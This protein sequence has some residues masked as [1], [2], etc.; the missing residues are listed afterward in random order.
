MRRPRLWPSQKGERIDVVFCEPHDMPI[1]DRVMLY[2]LIRGLKPLR[3][4]EIGVRW[5]GSARIVCNAMESN[6]FGRAV[7]LDPDL[8][9]FR[10]KPSETFGRF[11]TIQG[12]SPE[13]IG[14]AVEKLEGQPDF[15]FIDAVHTY[16]AVKM[17]L[18]GV[19]PYLAEHAHILLHDAF[20][21]GINQAAREF[22]EAH[23]DFFD[24][25]LMSRNASVGHPVSYT[26]MRLLRKGAVD[27]EAAL[28]EAHEREG[29][30]PPEFNADFWDHDPYAQR[31]GNVLGRP[32]GDSN[33]N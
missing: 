12:Y 5:G 8:S 31:M 23:S 22:L 30:P 21:Q 32:G 13:D 7:G 25:G 14:K 19:L 2:G 29:R 27:F 26:G 4:L 1:G 6:G 16:S 33:K 9:N 11:E 18:Q 15:V 24:L 20:H 3:Y 28:S 10:P 17:D